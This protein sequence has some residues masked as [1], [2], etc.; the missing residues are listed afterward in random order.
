[1]ILCTTI[2]STFSKNIAEHVPNKIDFKCNNS[3][4][5]VHIQR[6][7]RKQTIEVFGCIL[8][9]NRHN[10]VTRAHFGV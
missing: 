3:K 1:M 2:S 7:N 10:L 8:L 5:N 6:W 9:D 4:Q